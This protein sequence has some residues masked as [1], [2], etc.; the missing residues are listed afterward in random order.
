M[1]KFKMNK[2]LKEAKSLK[3]SKLIIRI[4]MKMSQIL[5]KKNKTRFN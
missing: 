3:N 5:M 4:K 2:T 1:T